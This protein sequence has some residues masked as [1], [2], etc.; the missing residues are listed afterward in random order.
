MTS[1]QT[2]MTDTRAAARWAPGVC[3]LLAFL[4]LA[5]TL[6]YAKDGPTA[7]ASSCLFRGEVIQA[8][9]Y[10]NV[11][12]YNRASP[13]VRTAVRPHTPLYPGDKLRVFGDQTLYIRDRP[14]ANTLRP[15]TAVDGVVEI[16]TPQ[17]CS[18]DRWS[19]ALLE[20]VGR[21]L[22]EW[23][24]GGGASEARFTLPSSRTRSPHGEETSLEIAFEDRQLITPDLESIA[25]FW[26]GAAETV[27]VRSATG[28]E[29]LPRDPVED[30][31]VRVFRPNRQFR[32]GESFTLALGAKNSRIERDITVVLSSELPIPDFKGRPENLN[33]EE[34]TI[35]ALWLIAEGPKEWRLQG[36]SLLAQ[37]AE[38]HYA[39]WKIWDAVRSGDAPALL[40]RKPL[41]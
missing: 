15:I 16:D 30:F 39:A 13:Q 1:V 9:D 27:D 8:D 40:E 35:L 32:V 4:L 25:V 17:T 41:Q 22:G 21:I 12:L 38:T 2:L 20:T 10:E 24:A 14:Y 23:M 26:F 33:D 7:P 37:A 34:S 18:P 5:P 3:G 11:H 36:F 6:A 29:V 28:G 31:S 19:L